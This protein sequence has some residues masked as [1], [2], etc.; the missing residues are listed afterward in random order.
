MFRS[1]PRCIL[2]ERDRVKNELVFTDIDP[3]RGKAVQLL[4]LASDPAASPE[5]DLSPDGVTVAIV[6]LDD[7]KDRMRL[8]QLDSKTGS[9]TGRPVRRGRYVFYLTAKD[10]LGAARSMKVSILIRP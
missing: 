10:E 1:T 4:R 7:A 8:V 5:W 9:I 3:V 2:G 6:N